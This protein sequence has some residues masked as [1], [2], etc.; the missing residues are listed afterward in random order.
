MVAVEVAV[1]AR[2]IIGE[3]PTWLASEG[4]LY[5]IDIKRPALHRYI[6]ANEG[7]RMWSLPSD[8]GAF[9]LCG[10]GSVIVALRHGLHRLDLS[11]GRLALLMPPP[12]DPSLFRFNEGI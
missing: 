8:V 9:A 1:A 5:W 7:S 2:A 6:P 11:T 10:D 3:S 12:F 4:A